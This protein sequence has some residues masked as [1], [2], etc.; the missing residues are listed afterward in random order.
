MVTTVKTA[1][2]FQREEHIAGWKHGLGLN[3][4]SAQI[5]GSKTA[6]SVFRTKHVRMDVS[7]CWIPYVLVLWLKL[8]NFIVLIERPVFLLAKGRTC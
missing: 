6:W 8:V 2:A 5:K 7:L 3:E 4:K 1:D